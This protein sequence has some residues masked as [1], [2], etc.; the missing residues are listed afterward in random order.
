M[1][2]YLF[3]LQDATLMARASISVQTVP[4]VCSLLPRAST[5]PFI[6]VLRK[7]RIFSNN[8]SSLNKAQKPS[9]KFHIC[10]LLF[11]PKLLNLHKTTKY[12]AVALLYTIPEVSSPSTS[13]A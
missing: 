11:C 1:I 2:R 4:Y 13:S 6:S 9:E 8:R 10:S 5:H 12:N 3:K 7:Y